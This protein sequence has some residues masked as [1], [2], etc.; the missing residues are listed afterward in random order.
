MH[1]H[2]GT[3]GLKST[4]HHIT[5]AGTLPGSRI[6]HVDRIAADWYR[7]I[8]PVNKEAPQFSRGFDDQLLL[9][10]SGARGPIE[11]LV[12]LCHSRAPTRGWQLTLHRASRR[13]GK[14][15]PM[16][17]PQ[18]KTCRLHT[19]GQ[20]TWTDCLLRKDLSRGALGAGGSSRP[21]WSCDRVRRGHRRNRCSAGYRCEDACRVRSKGLT[22]RRRV[23]AARLLHL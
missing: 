17:A 7:C 12:M 16:P 10:K 11:D 9:T 13:T 23:R 6:R 2:I 20:G 4:F 19:P 18:S 14:A 5:L 15:L 3:K 8:C 1:S 21:P 22:G